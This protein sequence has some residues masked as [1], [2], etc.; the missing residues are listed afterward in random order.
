MRWIGAVSARPSADTGSV[1]PIDAT[2]GID[3]SDAHFSLDGPRIEEKRGIQ[4]S[5]ERGRGARNRATLVEGERARTEAPR[6]HLLR[7]GAPEAHGRN[8]DEPAELREGPGVAAHGPVHA[9]LRDGP[10]PSP[11]G[12]LAEPELDAEEPRALGVVVAAVEGEGGAGEDVHG[13]EEAE[14]DSEE[15][16]EL[17]EDGGWREGEHLLEGCDPQLD[18]RA[19]GEVCAG[20][21]GR[22]GGKRSQA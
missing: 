2:A 4:Q 7:D 15:G 19:A 3:E 17:C 12:V 21:R 9:A 5:T 13:A 22:R 8:P 14:D 16:A 10:R 20:R 6:E 11:V 1:R 18:V